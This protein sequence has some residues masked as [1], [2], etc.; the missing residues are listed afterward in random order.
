MVM[1]VLNLLEMGLGYVDVPVM[2]LLFIK[3]LHTVRSIINSHKF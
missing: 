1:A 3:T 2:S